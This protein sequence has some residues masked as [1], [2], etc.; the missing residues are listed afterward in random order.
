V[1]LMNRYWPQTDNFYWLVSKV[2]VHCTILHLHIMGNFHSANVPSGTSGVK[3]FF[4]HKDFL[5][6]ATRF[7]S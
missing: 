6:S 7:S 2:G 1:V 5:D 4:L 3:D